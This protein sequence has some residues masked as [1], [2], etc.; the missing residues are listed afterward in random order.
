MTN[1]V[2]L[3]LGAWKLA[4]SPHI[5]IKRE[6]RQERAWQI[7]RKIMIKAVEQI[8]IRSLNNE[9]ICKSKL[10]VEES[11][12]TVARLQG[13]ISGYKMLV[14]LVINEYDIPVYMLEELPKQ[15]PINLSEIEM[16]ELAELNVW[17]IALKSDERWALIEDSVEVETKSMKDYL[18]FS[19]EKTRDLDIQQGKYSALTSYRTFLRD[20]EREVKPG[21]EKKNKQ[22]NSQPY[23]NL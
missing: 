5:K 7:R 14:S 16:L 6:S 20:I 22:G 21:N 2:R 11:G 4:T 8:I 18:L 3:N 12:R 10:E 13:E 23:S 1:V 15:E 17:A 9:E 19:A